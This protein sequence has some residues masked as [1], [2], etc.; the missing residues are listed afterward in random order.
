MSSDPQHFPNILTLPVTTSAASRDVDQPCIGP[1]PLKRS[2]SAN[3]S[4]KLKILQDS[5]N[6]PELS[7]F[8]AKIDEECALIESINSSQSLYFGEKAAPTCITS[9]VVAGGEKTQKAVKLRGTTSGLLLVLLVVCAIVVLVSTP[10]L[11]WTFARK[12]WGKVMLAKEAPSVFVLG[13]ILSLPAFATAVTFFV[14]IASIIVLRER[15]APFRHRGDVLLLGISAGL[16]G[17]VHV[18]WA[19]GW[20]LPLL[21]HQ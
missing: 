5:I 7:R 4:S 18:V 16:V 3:G 10:T 20:V 2:L 8:L 19:L 21:E 13:V 1:W 9:L 15:W 6:K 14:A 17:V 12:E 11:A